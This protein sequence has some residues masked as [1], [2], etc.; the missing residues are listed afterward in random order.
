MVQ[1]RQGKQRPEMPQD[2]DGESS[3]EVVAGTQCVPGPQG[4]QMRK[5]WLT[6]KGQ[7][8]PAYYREP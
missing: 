2:E 1:T 8:A 3:E 7:K 6:I 5:I 4:A